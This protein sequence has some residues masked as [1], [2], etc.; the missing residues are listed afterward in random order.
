MM[1]A[2]SLKNITHF[3][4]INRNDSSNVMV[5]KTEVVGYLSAVILYVVIVQIVI[6]L[7]LS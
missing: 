5:D 1:N 6:A 4:V 2:V 3:L 7:I